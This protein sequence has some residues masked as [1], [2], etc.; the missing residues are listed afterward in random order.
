MPNSKTAFATAALSIVGVELALVMGGCLGDGGADCPAPPAPKD[1]A[2]EVS[3]GGESGAG[4]VFLRFANFSPD[5]PPVDFCVAPHGASVFQ[6]PLVAGLATL[7]TSQGTT[8]DAGTPS[9]SYSVMSAYVPV[10]AP[11]TT[12]QFDVKVVPAGSPDC[13]SGPEASNMAATVTVDVGTFGTVA[14][15]GQALPVAGRPGLQLVGLNDDT[16]PAGAE[17]G[18]P[19][20]Y[21]RFLHA[22]PLE[23]AVDFVLG[24]VDSP[25]LFTRVAFGKTSQLTAADAGPDAGPKIDKGGYTSRAAIAPA[26]QI[27]LLASGVMPSKTVLGVTSPNGANTGAILTFVL[28]GETAM[29]DAGGDAGGG[30]VPLQLLQ[31]IDNG[32]TTGLTSTCA[33]LPPM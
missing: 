30:D 4:T 5:A 11:M 29:T 21:L 28:V 6:G 13:S 23:P 16:L 33:P 25:P 27:E 3:E 20:L 22:S 17:A 14:L 31:C 24:A 1:A 15:L 26:T 9:I 8:V 2:V 10:A 12:T 7:L 18:S 32:A 19:K